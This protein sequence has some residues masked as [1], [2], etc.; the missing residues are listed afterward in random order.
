MMR[1]KIRNNRIRQCLAV[2]LV[3]TFVITGL[4]PTVVLAAEE[5]NTVIIDS[6]EAFEKFAKQASYDAW[7]QGK[8]VVLSGDLDLTGKDIVPVPTFGGVFDGNGYTIKISFEQSGSHQGLFRYL[9]KG[10]MIKE[11]HVKGTV[12]PSGG[13]SYVGG[14]VGNNSGKL[15]KCTF[16]GSVTGKSNVGGIVGIN[17]AGGE[18]YGCKASGTVQAEHY[19]GGIAGQNLG[20]ITQ[21]VNDS[22]VNTV[23]RE[24]NN[25]RNTLFDDSTDLSATERVNTATDTGGI[26][27]YSAGIVQGCTNNSE[28]GYP[29]VGYNVGGIAGRSSGRL[30]RCENSGPIYGRKDV[31]GIIGQMVP[32][33][34]LQFSPDAL[35]QLEKELKELQTLIDTMLDHADGS[36]STMETNLKTIADTITEAKE[37]LH[38]LSDKTIDWANGNIEEI[39]NAAELLF[40]TFSRI[41]PLADELSSISDTIA[42][43]LEQCKE[44]FNDISTLAGFSSDA[45]EDI[46]RSFDD[47]AAANASAKQGLTKISSGISNLKDAIVS[48]DNQEEIANAIQLIAEG[49]SDWTNALETM[50]ASLGMLKELLQ[51]VQDWG[52]LNALR[53]PIVQLLS[54]MVDAVQ[55][56]MEGSQK[57]RDGIS[58]L[59]SDM[60]VDWDGVKEAI[61]DISSGISDCRAAVSSMEEAFGHLRD[62]LNNIQM[63]SEQIQVIADDLEEISGI[64]QE[65]FTQTGSFLQDIKAL[66]TDLSQQDPVHL[67]GFDSDYRAASD[68]LFD[69]FSVLSE[70]IQTLGNSAKDADAVFMADL[71]RLNEQFAAISDAV[72]AAFSSGQQEEPPVFEDTSEEN[73]NAI[74]M[75]KVDSCQN[76]GSVSGD[77]NVGGVAGSMAIEYDLD[78]ESDISREGTQSLHFQFETK[79]ILQNCLNSGAI[80][81]KKNHAGSIVGLMELGLIHK[82]EGYGK[83]QSTDGSYV[84]GIAGKSTSTIQNSYAKCTLDGKQYV[85]GIAGFGYCMKNCRS[86]VE[87]PHADAFVGAIAGERE[88][89]QTVSG[90][91]FVSDSLAGIDGISYKDVAE[92]MDY[93]SFMK[94]EGLPEEFT[95]FTLTYIA[96]D[97]VVETVPFSYGA[98]L[99]D[100]QVP[101]LPAKEGSYGAWEECDYGRLTF[102]KDIHAVYTPY[103]TTIASDAKR[104]DIHPAALAEGTFDDTAFLTAKQLE[105]GGLL[106]QWS[107]RLS[108]E[109]IDRQAEYTIR[110][111]PPESKQDVDLYAVTDGKREKLSCEKDGSYLVFTMKGSEITLEVGQANDHFWIVCMAI[112]ATLIAAIVVLCTI[113]YAKKGTDRK[114][115]TGGA[116][117]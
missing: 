80:T 93:P 81:A 69:S 52:E 67:N 36:S 31:G 61:A 110:F 19:T 56:M 55:S 1:M 97:K 75:G 28:I 99:S 62:A 113:R 20:T 23:D 111:L 84:G 32:D 24:Y 34:I 103:I 40:D 101:E 21:C 13:Q 91:Y 17:E 37:H 98:D 78:P 4:A 45:I 29:H 26:A 33:I 18:I 92:P 12:A 10:G 65:A 2:L 100:R 107:L 64:F 71:R 108:G 66:L 38:H 104:D 68:A 86:L 77:I 96:D 5:Q 105:A 25:D 73:I 14:I 85:G 72:I 49:A 83:V 106:E 76:T 16:E 74:V 117:S 47:L 22:A 7:S 88:P 115:K 109:G 44:L 6:P 94:L 90:N 8:T 53:E 87:I 95:K 3:I 41:A 48:E 11:L 30:E 116:T 39:D 79:A 112:A 70:H 82:C 102:S 50:H 42:S 46:Q 114:G 59:P 58:K 43:G 60:A 15:M 57:I 35:S 27:G 54:D 9:Q 89:N 51:S 63:A